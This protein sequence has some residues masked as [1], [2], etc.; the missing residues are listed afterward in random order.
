MMIFAILICAC[1]LDFGS[2][3]NFAINSFLTT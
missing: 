3:T 1:T 2:S